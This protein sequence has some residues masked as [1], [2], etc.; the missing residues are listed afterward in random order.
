LQDSVLHTL[1]KDLL[2]KMN[3]MRIV[4]SLNFIPATNQVHHVQENLIQCF[5]ADL[6]T[7]LPVDE[8]PHNQGNRDKKNVVGSHNFVPPSEQLESL[9]K[10]TIDNQHNFMPA[11]EKSSST[12]SVSA[13]VMKVPQDIYFADDFPSSVKIDSITSGRLPAT[14]LLIVVNTRNHG[15]CMLF[16]WRSSYQQILALEKGG[17][18]V[19]E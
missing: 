14:E 4:D 17:I 13:N 1:Q 2:E 7:K 18:Q 3:K 9:N 15:K 12:S 8:Q 6:S 10:I 5:S 16:S 11:V 19:V